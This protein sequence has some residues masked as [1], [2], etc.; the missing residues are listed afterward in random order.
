M[1]WFFRRNH[2][3]RDIGSGKCVSTIPK[4]SDCVTSVDFSFSG[5]NIVSSS[6]DGVVR[7]WD[8]AT[9]VYFKTFY[10]VGHPPVGFVRYCPIGDYILRGSLDGKIRMWS[11]IDRNINI[12]RHSYRHSYI[13][14]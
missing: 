6:Y 3:L 1:F 14:T 9:S 5:T 13:E 11:I 8:V 7:I 12:I 10:S 2:K 4:H